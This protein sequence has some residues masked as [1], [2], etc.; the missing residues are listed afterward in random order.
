MVVFSFLGQ[1]YEYND[2]KVH[3]VDTAMVENLQA[4]L[5]FYIKREIQMNLSY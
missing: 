2:E 1:W 3:E 4:Y 5:L